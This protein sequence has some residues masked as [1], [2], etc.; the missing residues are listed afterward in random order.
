MATKPCDCP[1]HQGAEVPLDQFY[2]VC[3]NVMGRQILSFFCTEFSSK[4]QVYV[5]PDD[6]N[7]P[8]TKRKA[9]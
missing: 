3:S 6:V 8:A 9:A 5:E 7:P 1:T 4:Q 2:E